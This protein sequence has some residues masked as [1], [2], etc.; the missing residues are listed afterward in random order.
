MF[1]CWYVV[2]N[3]MVIIFKTIYM[4]D[5]ILVI[6]GKENDGKTTTA[7]LVYTKLLEITE[8]EHTIYTH[9]DW[10]EK[11]VSNVS[12]EVNDEG[13][14]Y[15][16]VVI[17]TIDGKTI[18]IISAGD[19]A[20]DLE[21]WIDRLEEEL[22]QIDVLIVC[23]RTHNR[24]GSSYRM[25]EEKFSEDIIER[26]VLQKSVLREDRFNEKSKTVEAIVSKVK[27]LIE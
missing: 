27:V 2:C 11:K 23:S 13:D 6:V 25:L 3:K 21:D 9:P 10:K 18:V 16:F 22:K 15:D 12:L 24:K 17:I 5:N 26:F 8:A 19:K 4:I 7:G 20:K 14:N 1:V